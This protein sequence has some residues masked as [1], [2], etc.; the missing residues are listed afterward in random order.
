[1]QIERQQALAV[2]DHQT[3]PFKEQRPGQDDAAAVDGRDRGSTG[4]A[5]IEP[6]MRALYGTVEDARDSEHVGDPGIH[7]RHEGTFPFAA[8]AEGSKNLG[9]GFLVLFDLARWN[10]QQHAGIALEFH[11]N[12][13][14]E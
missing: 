9:F 1:M 4:N 13:L 12:F 3:I 10:L 2:I 5:E 8:G 6:L 14:F 11:S 7:R